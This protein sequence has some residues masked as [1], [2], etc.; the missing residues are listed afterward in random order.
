L[1]EIEGTGSLGGKPDRAGGRLSHLCAGRCRDEREGQRVGFGL[2][3]AP[4]EVGPGQNV[5][6]LVVSTHLQGTS[7]FAVED[8]VVVGL[9][10][11]VVEF[12]EG[13]ALFHALPVGLGRKH[14]IDAEMAADVAQEGQVVERSQP[15]R[16]VDHDGVFPRVGDKAANLGLDG[17]PVFLDGF[18]PSASGATRFCHSDRQPWPFHRPEPRSGGGRRA[19]CAM[20]MSGIM[21]PTCRLDA[22]GSNPA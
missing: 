6:P 2:V 16:V 20:A 22:V 13:Q 12:D 14:A 1:V 21:L 4:N 3:Q 19:K 7:V 5:A 17:A 15:F 9:Q 10:D 11:L 8:Q 18:R